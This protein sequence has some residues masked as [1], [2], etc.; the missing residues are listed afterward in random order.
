MIKIENAVIK[1]QK[2][3]W[4]GCVF[5]PTD[6]V[7]DPWGRRILDKMSKDK[8]IRDV[9]VYTMFEDIVYV[10]EDGELCYDFRLSDLRLDYL[11]ERGY[12]LTLAYAGIPDAIASSTLFQT[13]SAK[14]KTRYKGK[15]WNTSKPK[16][17]AL[18]EELCYEYTKHIVERYGIE[19]V[20]TWHCHCF[21]EPDHP[22]YFMGEF[23]AEEGST[24]R[25]CEEYC[26]LYAAFER[27]VRRVSD[28]ILIGGPALASHMDFLGG[29]LDYVKENGLKL[30]FVT[31]HYYGTT[32]K[33]LHEKGA[34]ITVEALIGKQ[35]KYERVV[36]E[37]GFS[38]IPLVIDE[39]GMICAGFVDAEKYPEVLVRETE[40]YA[41]YFA[42]LIARLIEEASR[43]DNLLICLS[44]QHEMTKDFTGFRNFFSLN[45]FAKPVYN[46]YVLAAK[47]GENL[48]KAEKNNE[49]VFVVPTKND[50]GGYSVLLSYSSEYFEEDLP[51]VE[52]T[53]T[54]EEDISDKTVT[55]W[56]IDKETTNP[57]RLYQKMGIDEPTEEEI[58][59]LREE[60]KMKP[61][62]VQKGAESLT[63]K[64]SA[65]ATY[66]VT[67]E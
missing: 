38:H 59:I 67:V 13:S 10:G 54:F 32:P 57:Y 29:W 61:V 64:F 56:C 63:L 12:R 66:L 47:L 8:A 3:F 65:N 35:K 11:V 2:N 53:I 18:W 30:D 26:L 41:A 33:W 46:C 16:D 40:V 31:G 6:A 44:G 15:M 5:H 48:L 20:K 24:M 25:R 39:W 19:T 45:F 1:K 17:Y 60:G 23:G 28:E 42:K 58:K 21:N 55:V 51:E 34:R 27:G 7:E 22:P 36:A 50:Q 9:R 4:N 14:N 43:I 62:K 52:E 49:N 37:H